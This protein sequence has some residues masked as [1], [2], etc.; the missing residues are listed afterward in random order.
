MRAWDDPRIAIPVCC[1]Y[2]TPVSSPT[3]RPLRDAL[4]I[5]VG[6]V[7]AGMTFGIIAHDAAVGLGDTMGFSLLVFAGAS[8][9]MA[10]NLISAGSTVVQI[11][12]ATFLLNFRHFLMS[13]S[14]SQKLS[15]SRTGIR[16]LL[17]FGV[18]DETFAVAASRNRFDAKYL[19]ILEF[20][21]WFSWCAGTGIGFLAGS[22]LPQSVEQAMG[23]ALYALFAALL[24]P[25]VNTRVA[26]LIPAIV[27]AGLHLLLSMLTSMT[28]G[29]AFVVSVT[30]AA[31]IGSMVVPEDRA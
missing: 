27:A 23:V 1:P 31:A 26:L 5:M 6:Y 7:P 25:M 24:T 13:A 17:A 21:A 8:Q 16:M 4:P 11:I 29:W 15:E 3:S 10:I 2:S 20:A 19:G 14:L 30:V 9:Y 12:V 28:A 22:L 18:T